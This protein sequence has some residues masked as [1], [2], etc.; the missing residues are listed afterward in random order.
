MGMERQSRREVC[1]ILFHIVIQTA[2][3][4]CASPF[5]FPTILGRT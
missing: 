1:T 2:R 3:Q 4:I 5:G